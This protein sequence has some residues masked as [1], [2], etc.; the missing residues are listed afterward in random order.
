MP[1]V[2]NRKLK[3]MNISC[4]DS[5]ISDIPLNN[6][7]WLVLYFYPKD[8]TSGCSQQAEDFSKAITQ[9]KRH[10]SQ[11]IGVSRDSIKSHQNFI[12]KLNIKYPLISDPEEKL[13]NYFKVMQMKS[14]YG[15]QYLGVERSTFLI[16]PK[17][18]LRYEWRKV[19]VKNHIDDVLE[20]IQHLT[21]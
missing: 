1:A 13:C 16:D 14:M 12:E 8:N 20:K 10:N 18:K 4:T 6:G 19:K 17:G 3:S 15:R 9:F 7:D 2:L 5:N 11:I 21:Q